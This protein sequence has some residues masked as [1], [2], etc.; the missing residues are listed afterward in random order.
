MKLKLRLKAAKRASGSRGHDDQE[1]QEKRGTM[2]K[3][4]GGSGGDELQEGQKRGEVRARSA[5]PRFV[6]L[7]SCTWSRYL[8]VADAGCGQKPM[9]RARAQGSVAGDGLQGVVGGLCWIGG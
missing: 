7:Q 4:D 6:T 2:K 1:G 3:D 9:C 5:G 8:V